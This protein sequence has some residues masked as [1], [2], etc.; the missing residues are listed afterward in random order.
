MPLPLTST[1]TTVNVQQTPSSTVTQTSQNQAF[2][3]SLSKTVQIAFQDLPFTIAAG[4]VGPYTTFD[5]QS[6]AAL[7]FPYPPQPSQNQ[8]ASGTLTSQMFLDVTCFTAH[9]NIILA[10]WMD[11]AGQNIIFQ[12][13]NPTGLHVPY[14]AL[15]VVIRIT[16]NSTQVS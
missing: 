11:V 2:S 14:P 6:V 12:V 13:S 7:K 3:K 4:S 5:G 9:L 1:Q 15:S 16:N 8:G 10:W